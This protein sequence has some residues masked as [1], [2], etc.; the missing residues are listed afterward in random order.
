M[1]II[2]LYVTLVGIL[3]VGL[4]GI[5]RVGEKL[6][7]PINIAGDWE[8]YDESAKAIKE[9]CIPLT[10]QKKEPQ[11]NIEQSGIYLK[12]IFNDVNHTEMSGR[13]ENNK[14]VFRRTVKTRIDSVN[15]CG[16]ELLIE[17]S[18]KIIQYGDEPDQLS[19]EWTTP[20]CNKCGHI[21][22]GAVRKSKE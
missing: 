13:L 9:S 19:G 17:L 2:L 10:F 15:V 7:A 16:N 11:F 12:A 1:K 6:K 21:K 14:M 20:G 3:L 4:L 5:L 8:I 22:F 18:V